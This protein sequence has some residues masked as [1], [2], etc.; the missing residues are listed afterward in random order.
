M[1]KNYSFIVN[2]RFLSQKMTGVHRYAYEMCCAL[3]RAGVNFLVVAPKNL[4][5]DYDICFDLEMCGN[6]TSHFWEQIELPLYIN[7]NHKN[8]LLISFTGLGSIFYKK[9]ICTIHDISYLIHPKWFSKS[10]YFLYK[11]LTPISAKRA[12]KIITVS[13]FSKNEIVTRLNIPADK[14]EVIYNAVTN[15]VIPNQES[16][17]EKQNYILSV[18]SLEPRKNFK[19]LIQ[20][21]SLIDNEDYKLL[22]VGKKNRIFNRVDFAAL[23]QNRSIVF[24]GY[25]TDEELAQYYSKASVFVS[26]SLYEGFGIPNLEAM[27]NACPVVASDIP[28]HREVCGDVAIYFNPYDV[29]DIAKAITKVMEDKELQNRMVLK[30]KEQVKLFSWDKSANLLLSLIDT[31]K[32]TNIK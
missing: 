22:I 29:E 3:K 7:K 20:A 2:G 11:W 25:V 23:E 1:N 6:F 15:K 9:T 10:Y 5:P 32:S 31:V 19:R 26:P 16:Q 27:T 8:S 17:I 4:V 14:I 30:G 28:P 21:F 24:T 18:S 12:L 13:E